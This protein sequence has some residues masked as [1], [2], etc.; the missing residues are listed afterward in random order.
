MIVGMNLVAFK[1]RVQSKLKKKSGLRLLETR[2]AFF[3]RMSLFGDYYISE[4]R[5]GNRIQYITSASSL[6][7]AVKDIRP[8]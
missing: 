4:W 8:I 1:T 6:N 2:F 3:L 5:G 7:S